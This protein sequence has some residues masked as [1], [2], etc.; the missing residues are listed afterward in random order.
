MTKTT[1]PA[2]F[3]WPFWLSYGFRPF[4]LLGALAMALPVLIWLFV[5]TGLELPTAFVPRDWHVHTMLFGALPAIAAGFTLTAVSNWTGRRP[6]SGG[7]LLT[8]V[9]IWLAGR[10]ATSVSA[11]IGLGP[12]AVVDLLFLPA[13][14]LVL[15]REVVAAGNFRNLRVVAL[16]GLIAL[17]DLGFHLEVAATG[18]ADVSIR[19]GIA[20]ILVLVM[21][22]GGRII[23]AFTRNWLKARG[24]T[25]FPAPF[26]TVDAASMIVSIL[27][28][29]LWTAPPGSA[30]SAAVLL[31]AGVSNAARLARWRGWA[32][33]A[34]PLLMVLH[35]AYATVPLGFVAVGAAILAPAIVEPAAALHLWTAGTFGLM[36]LA[37]MARASRGHSGRPLT[38]GAFEVV[39]FVLVLV[40][41]VARVAAPYAGG[42]YL[43][44]ID[45][46]G[47]AW[48]AAFLGFAG[49]YAKLLLRPSRNPR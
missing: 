49:G 27:A 33:R 6:V 39:L 24:A 16:I 12:A 38:A 48:T 7:L 19:A 15:G 13:L 11:W 4:F 25:H 32:T 45:I 43:H 30:I 36:T 17:A 37:V 20:L 26:S 3:D 46:A 40:A 35:G 23:P 31:A 9:L 29:A 22:I 14:A 41:T 5:I 18:V 8:L 34:E 44:V 10:I 47:L 21:L 2:R 28:L 42:L 1:P